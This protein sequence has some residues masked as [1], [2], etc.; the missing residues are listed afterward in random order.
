MQTGFKNLDNILN[1]EKSKVILLTGTNF[2]DILSGDI[3]NNVCLKQNC[4]VLEV[5]SHKKEY[6]IKRLLVNESNVE[7]NKWTLKDKYTKQELE[8]IGQNTVNLIEV[9]NRLPTII[10][11]GM[12]LFNLKKVTKLVLDFANVYADRENVEALVVLDI[13]P[14]NA[15]YIKIKKYKR[16]IINSFKEMNKV[17]RKLNIP[18]IIV[19]GIYEE[20]KYNLETYQINHL[21]KQDIKYI[22]K[23]N[24]YLDKTIIIN[25]DKRQKDIYNLDVYDRNKKLGTAKLKYDFKYRRFMEKKEKNLKT[26]YML[27][28]GNNK[29]DLVELLKDLKG[30]IIEKNNSSEVDIKHSFEGFTTYISIKEGFFKIL[31]NYWNQGKIY[32]EIVASRSNV[33]NEILKE[34]SEQ[35]LKEKGFTKWGFIIDRNYDERKQLYKEQTN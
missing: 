24:K 17:N 30:Y 23:I 18:I 26:E 13:F 25:L 7:Y 5:V 35:K 8:Q 3:A 19:Y 28:A 15:G 22:D 11:Q 14:L 31:A 12:N 1:L 16:N 4:E 27:I 9:T 2:A 6:L 20:K 21:E 10:E 32:V 34:S 29:K 33:I